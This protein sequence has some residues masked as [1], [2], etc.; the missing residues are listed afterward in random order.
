[1]PFAVGRLPILPLAAIVSIIVLLIH[2][3]WAI[4]A[5]GLLAVALTAVAF[6]ARQYVRR[7]NLL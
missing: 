2:F 3:D 5:A 7:A 1:V 6:L 4:Y